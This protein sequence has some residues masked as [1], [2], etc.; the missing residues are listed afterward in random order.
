LFVRDTVPTSTT[1]RYHI[2]WYRWR[3]RF[4]PPRTQ[5]VSI[6]FRQ[7]VTRRVPQSTRHRLWIVLVSTHLTNALRATASPSGEM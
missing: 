5:T 6:L 2:R 4:F 1:L 7:A 3:E